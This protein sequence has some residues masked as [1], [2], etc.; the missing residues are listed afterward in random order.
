MGRIGNAL[1]SVGRFLKRAAKIAGSHISDVAGMSWLSGLTTSSG[2]AVTEDN[3]LTYSAVWTAVRLISETVGALPLPLY[4]RLDPRGRERAY[5][6]PVYRL[7][8]DQPNP[9]IPAFYFR[10]TMTAHAVTRGNAYAEIERDG[11]GR[12]IALWGIHPSRVTPERAPDKSIVYEV[13][14]PG[15]GVATIPARDMLHIRGLGGDGLVGYSVVRYARESIGM[16]LAT[17]KFGGSLFGNGVRPS[18]TLKH[19]GTLSEEAQERLRKQV[20][21][22]VTG[23]GKWLKLLLLEE[24]LEFEN[25]G[26]NPD[27]AQFLETR[28]FQITEIARWFRVQPHKLM[29]LER[30]TFSNIEHQ[31]LEFVVDTLTP[32]LVRWESE[33]ALKLLTPAERIQY[34]ARHVVAALVRGDLHSRYQAYSI[35]RQWGWLSADDVRELEDMNPLPDGAGAH[36]LVPLNMIPAADVGK[37]RELRLLLSRLLP[38]AVDGNGHQPTNVG[39]GERG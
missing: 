36:Y 16:G 23:E 30:A 14:N 22:Q 13:R 4:R 34:Y 5:G 39:V 28:K 10:E 6:H 2:V 3:A 19:P 12:P 1:A 37:D 29:D 33:I 25:I 27:D 11:A 38:P 31:G 24:G 17:E 18:G 9:E 21:S 7:L 26:I 15:A 32:W 35:G 20:T 8:H